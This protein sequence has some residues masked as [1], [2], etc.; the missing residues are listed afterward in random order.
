MRCEPVCESACPARA[1]RRRRGLSLL[2]VILALAILAG[3]VAMLG[4][5]TRLGNQNAQAARYLTQAQLL[6]QSKLAEIITGYDLPQSVQLAP[7]EADVVP[8]SNWLYS[9]DVLPTQREGLIVVQVTVEQDAAAAHRR[10]IVY[11]LVRWLPDPEYQDS[12]PA[13]EEVEQ[14]DE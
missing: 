8:G 2:E 12:D 7:F 13:Y 6:C 14:S 3:A 9:V 4:E 1:A 5:L 11:S 10:P